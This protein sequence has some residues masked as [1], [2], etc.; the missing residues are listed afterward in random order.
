MREVKYSPEFRRET[1]YLQVAITVD[2]E[3]LEP[4]EIVVE[5]PGL[6]VD[7]GYLEPDWR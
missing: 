7:F 6:T 3:D 1:V 4:A 5:S 2:K